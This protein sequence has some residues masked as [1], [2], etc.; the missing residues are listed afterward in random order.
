MWDLKPDAPA[1]IRGEF[2]PIN[3]NVPG[4]EICELFPKIAAMMD[5][6]AIIR[7][8][9]DSDG[10]HD[11][12]Q[13]MTGRKKRDTAPGGGWPAAG[14]WVSRLGG[15]GQRGGAGE[16]GADVPDRQPRLGRAGDGG[17]PG[18]GAR[19]VQR[20]S[21][22]KP[23]EKPQ[24]MVLQGITLERLRDRDRLRQ[25]FDRFRR[26]ADA[27]GRMES[28]DAFAQQALGILT[29]V[30]AGRRAR[31]VEG[32]PE[33][34]GALRRSD[35]AFRRDGAPRMVETSASPAAWSRPARASSRSTSAAGTGTAATA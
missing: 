11:A 26:E 13:C 23:R 10:D 34:R 1:E 22:A 14:G 4:I 33:D 18:H 20:R 8:I 30:E 32:R 2:K 28:I 6:F 9:A 21:A 12:Y 31:P 27:A 29:D 17:L 24:G 16:R 7:S 5:K 15:A 19:P 25:S 3:T 35:E